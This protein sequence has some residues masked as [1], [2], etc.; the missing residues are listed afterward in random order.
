MSIDFH[1]KNLYEGEKITK[2]KLIERLSTNFDIVKV[3][4]NSDGIVNY[5]AINP[6]DKENI[7][8]EN[9]F[10]YHLQEDGRY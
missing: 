3:T 6:K 5:F 4:T 9:G 7:I 8:Y 1:Y 2:E 10:E